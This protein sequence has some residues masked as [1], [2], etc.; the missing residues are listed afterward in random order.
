MV[1]DLVVPF[2]FNVPLRRRNTSTVRQKMKKILLLIATCALLM[3]AV[4][5]GDD[6]PK[7]GDG[8][9]TVNTPMVNHMYN[10]LTDN[11]VG[12]SRTHN[13]LTIDTVKHTATLELAYNDG[14]EKTLKLDDLKAQ[15]KRLGFYE[16]SSSSYSQFSG[17]VDFNE[18]A[19]RY[20]FT[21]PEGLRVIS[22]TP[23]VFFLK[24]QNTI[25]YDDTTKTTVME[26]A[27]YQFTVDPNSLKAT[28][29]VMDIVH[30]KDWRYFISITGNSVPV[31]LTPNGYIVAGENIKTNA[32]Y[33][34][35][36]DSIHASP[37]VMS[38][39]KYPFKT[40]NA[41][42]DLV[43]DHLNATFMMG[44]SATVTATGR[45]YPD[46]TAY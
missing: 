21:T 4:S 31:T 29:K 38:T 46:Y 8:V 19:M 2:V 30:I 3:G 44:G 25:E 15:P 39:D 33:R 36:N 23:E 22:T 14:S 16:L 13:K 12:L 43:N 32:L 42:V 1:Q 9:F 34:A 45:T 11:I 37:G 18:G 6:E 28:V 10:T 27:M 24:T 41:D 17:Y 40:F 26:N 5:C 7:R 20:R 35:H